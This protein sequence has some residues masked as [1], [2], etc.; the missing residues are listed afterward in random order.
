MTLTKKSTFA[1]YV[2]QFIF[3]KQ[4]LLSLLAIALISLSANAQL[5]CDATFSVTQNPNGSYTF[6]STG[7]NQAGAIYNWSLG[8]GSTASGPTATTTYNSFGTFMVCLVV[9]YQNCIDSSCVPVNVIN[10][11]GCAA[12]FNTFVSGNTVTLTNTSTGA[13]PLTYAWSADGGA[14]IF[15]TSANPTYTNVPGTYNICLYIN[16]AVTNCTDTACSTVTFLSSP[17]LAGFYIY[18][19]TNG[20]AHTYIGVNTS[21]G[22]IQTYTWTWGDGSSSTGMY[23]S[24]TYATA[25][26]YQI[27]LFVAGAPN[28]NCVDSFC[29]NATI[30]KTNAMYSVNFLN[31]LSVNSVDQQ[32]V[33]VHPNPA[34]DVI[35]FSGLN[36]ANAVAEFYSMSGSKVAT[37]NVVDNKQ[38][39]VSE[40]PKGMYFIRLTTSEGKVSNVK[41]VRN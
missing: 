10:S 40:L 18:P 36:K 15:S 19:D 39:V 26:N 3:M 28:T 24:H 38:I 12:G 25:G 13:N 21:N 1:S 33:S 8:N 31:P 27:C 2:K 16:D 22:P 14:T 29:M 37:Y 34:T 11:A 20:P 35:S 9:Q 30:N 5:L 6:T 23:P 7:V 32:K 4:K 41:F 17:C